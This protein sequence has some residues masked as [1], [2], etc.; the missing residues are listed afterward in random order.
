[1]RLCQGLNVEK[2][3]IADLA[4]SEIGDETVAADHVAYWG[5]SVEPS[6]VDLFSNLDRVV[7][8]DAEIPNGT[9]YLGIPK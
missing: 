8:L 3:Q 2:S 4:P 6:D 7:D 5:Y 1:M 9:F